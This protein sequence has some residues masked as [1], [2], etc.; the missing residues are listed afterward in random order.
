VRGDVEV[1]YQR[2]LTTAPQRQLPPQQ[3]KTNQNNYNDRNNR[4]S[5]LSLLHRPSERIETASEDF[6]TISI[7]PIL[8]WPEAKEA[9]DRLEAFEFIILDQHSR[10]LIQYLLGEVFLY[11]PAI[12][13]H[14]S[15]FNH[16]TST[17]HLRSY[18]PV[19]Y[20]SKLIHRACLPIGGE[21]T[22]SDRLVIKA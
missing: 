6:G 20:R 15:R 9:C 12:K 3:Y 10:E 14:A 17:N 2:V 11:T 19:E 8:E 5:K 22:D 4:S 1:P 7:C 21:D 13:E 16:V 18:M